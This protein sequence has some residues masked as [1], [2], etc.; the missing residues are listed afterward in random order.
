MSNICLYPRYWD[1]FLTNYNFTCILCGFE[2]WPTHTYK[3][4]CEV[5]VSIEEILQ[6]SAQHT[7]FETLIVLS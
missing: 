5:S 3:Q 1:K 7:V 4:R 2:S 6:L